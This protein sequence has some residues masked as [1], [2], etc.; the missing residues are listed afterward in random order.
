MRLMRVASDVGGTFT[1][2]VAYDPTTG[3]LT[4][5]KVSTTP[6]N[7]AMG[8]IAGLRRALAMQG[9]S[10]ADVGYVGHGMTTATNAVIQRT[11]ALT[12]FVTNDGFRD[13]LLIGRQNR[14][15]LYDLSVVRNEQIVPRER[16]YTVP[17]RMDAAGREIRPLDEAALRE[18][19]GRLREDRVEA[20]A[21]TFLHAYA[22]PAHERRAAAVLR[23]ELPGVVVCISTDVLSEFR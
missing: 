23:D 22:N 5:A 18:V 16:C 2:S 1:D 10:G 7:R 9:R 8:T 20:V 11:G 14:P 4:V 13:I 17:G 12:A 21:V 19:A 6:E 3:R 15:S